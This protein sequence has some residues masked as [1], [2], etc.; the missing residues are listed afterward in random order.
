MKNQGPNKKSKL[1]CGQC[2]EVNQVISVED[3]TVSLACGHIRTSGLL[4]VEPG[5]VSLE[6]LKSAIGRKLFTANRDDEVTRQLSFDE[7]SYFGE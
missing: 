1:L 3:S 4:P 6:H 7:E 2:K 5:H